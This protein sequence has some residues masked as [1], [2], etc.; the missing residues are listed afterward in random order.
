MIICSTTNL[1]IRWTLLAVFQD[2]IA[3]VSAKIAFVDLKDVIH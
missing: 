3:A 1:M 2:V